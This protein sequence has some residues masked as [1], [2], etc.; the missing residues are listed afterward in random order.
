[1][2]DLKNN[3]INIALVENIKNFDYSYKNGTIVQELAKTDDVHLKEIIAREVRYFPA[4]LM[5]SIIEKYSLEDN[6][7]IKKYIARNLNYYYRNKEKRIELFDNLMHNANQYA[8]IAL[9]NSLNNIPTPERDIRFRRFFNMDNVVIKSA[10]VRNIETFNS[11]LKLMQ[12]W[13]DKLSEE[14][15]V[16]I[17]RSLC[18]S[19]RFLPDEMMPKLFV[20]L[21]NVKDMNAKE[22]LAE[23]LPFVKG[24]SSHPEWFE[25]IYEKSCN[26]V[27]R[28]LAKILPK[29]G[30]PVNRKK[31]AEMLY[32]DGDES[33]K[34]ILKTQKLV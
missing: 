27:K 20:K 2:F 17:K 12:K 15:H 34:E 1:M 7:T 6:N 18:E 31:W 4:D 32:A 13:I 30:S 5:H 24:F 10:L 19:I 23:T 28:E 26:S 21:L 8:S 29:V 16:I 33:V 14:K 22:Y 3:D 9:I 11:D 25:Q